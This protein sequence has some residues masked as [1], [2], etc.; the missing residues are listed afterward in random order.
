M[1]SVKII[2]KG[3]YF[4][5]EIPISY[6]KQEIPL[7]QLSDIVE[8][9]NNDFIDDAPSPKQYRAMS[10]FQRAESGTEWKDG[11]RHSSRNRM[12]TDYSSIIGTMLQGENSVP[13]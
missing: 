5:N 6:K 2:E 1:E 7:P 10:W 4:G 8:T 13:N 9:Q 12:K 11:K 3:F